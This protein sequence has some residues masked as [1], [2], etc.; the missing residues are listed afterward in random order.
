[1]IFR[2]NLVGK[3]FTCIDVFP[4]IRKFEGT[5]DNW[6][7]VYGWEIV[8]NDK[9]KD[10]RKLKRVRIGKFD[11][12]VIRVPQVHEF[13]E[14]VWCT[15]SKKRFTLKVPDRRLYVTFDGTNLELCPYPETYNMRIKENK[16]LIDAYRKDMKSAKEFFKK[17]RKCTAGTG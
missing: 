16:P 7:K 5:R 11:M 15:A 4:R 13:P 9:V 14:S 6:L 1:M 3:L 17:A 2:K 10:K 8:E 12:I